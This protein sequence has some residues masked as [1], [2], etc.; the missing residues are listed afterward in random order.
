MLL[1]EALSGTICTMQEFLSFICSSFS[2]GYFA[3]WR[4]FSLRR[5]EIHVHN[6]THSRHV[7]VVSIMDALP[8]TYSDP[9]DTF[10]HQD[11]SLA[12]SSAWL[13]ISLNAHLR[14]QGKGVVK[15]PHILSLSCPV[16]LYSGGLYQKGWGTGGLGW[17]EYRIEANCWNEGHG[18]PWTLS[19]VQCFPAKRGNMEREAT[20]EARGRLVS[21][22]Q[23][24]KRLLAFSAKSGLPIGKRR[25]LSDRKD[26]F[27]HIRSYGLFKTALLA[28]VYGALPAVTA[29]ANAELNDEETEWEEKTTVDLIK[30]FA[31][32]WWKHFLNCTTVTSIR[33][34]LEYEAVTHLTL[35][36]AD[37]L[38]KD[39]PKS[40]LRKFW[41]MGRWR[42]SWKI[43]S[44]AAYAMFIPSI[45]QFVQDEL[46]I[47]ILLAYRARKK[48]QLKRGQRTRSRE[49]GPPVD[50]WKTTLMNV[51][52]TVVSYTVIV[53]GAAVG[54]AIS[55]RYGPGICMLLAESVAAK[56]HTTN[57]N[58]NE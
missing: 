15:N 13:N 14:G 47:L 3:S 58:E 33:R 44:T 53:T 11:Y 6:L 50:F 31:T 5:T 26:P 40:A 54:T 16:Y 9:K 23:V 57:E 38:T 29:I 43:T 10:R 39:V 45:A 18:F 49:L 46:R 30:E 51:K 36:L 27:D 19:N 4:F 42:A 35:R 25:W 56:M 20:P 8:I 17:N 21:Q 7:N 32:A 52:A 1:C 12:T 48:R 22:T 37:R 41:R 24:A 28:T 2:T 55:P 34:F